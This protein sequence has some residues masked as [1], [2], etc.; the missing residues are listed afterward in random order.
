MHQGPHIHPITIRGGGH[1][2]RTPHSFSPAPHNRMGVRGDTPST[3]SPHMGWDA[4]GPPYP[5]YSDTG[6]GGATKAGPAPND[7]V[8]GGGSGGGFVTYMPP[9]QTVAQVRSG[10]ARGGGQQKQDPPPH[11]PPNRM[12]LRGDTPPPQVPPYGMGCTRTLIS[13]PYNDTGGGATK[14]GPPSLLSP[15]PHNRM[16]VRGAPHSLPHPPIWDGMHQDPHIHPITIRGG[17]KSRTLPLL[18]LHNGM[19]VR[20]DASPSPYEMG[21]IRTLISPPYNDMGGGTK[22]GPPSL[23]PPHNRMGVR[24]APHSLP[25]LPIWDGMHQDPHIPTL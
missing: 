19:G 13:P 17:H 2:S 4:P 11:Y 6:G 20:G 12:G 1:K 23:F 3:R 9:M 14:A 24:G 5:P 22:A 8:L 16:G 25:H 21:C 7:E 15:S 10:K 18:P